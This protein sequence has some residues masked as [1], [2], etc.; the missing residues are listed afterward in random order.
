MRL[1]LGFILPWKIVRAVRRVHVSRERSERPSVGKI[2]FIKQLV[3]LR[4][5]SVL[6]SVTLWIISSNPLLR[7]KKF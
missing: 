5:E 4:L 6:G 2:V 1:I 7:I 3:L